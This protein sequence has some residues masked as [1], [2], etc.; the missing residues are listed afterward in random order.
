M[1]KSVCMMTSEESFCTNYGAPLQG[2]ALYRTISSLGYD[3]NIVRYKSGTCTR[4]Y[5]NMKKVISIIKNNNLYNIILKIRFRASQKLYNKKLKQRNGLFLHFQ[6]EYMTFCNDKRITWNELSK[7]PIIADIYVCGSDQLWNPKFRGNA[8]DKGYF[9]AFAPKETKLI[10]Y[11]PSLAVPS[12]SEE[13][14]KDMKCLLERFDYVSVREKTGAKIV[15]D[16]IEKEVPVMLDPAFLLTKKEWKEISKPIKTPKKYILC[17]VFGNNGVNID[18]ITKISK[19]LNLPVISLAMSAIAMA[20][21][22]FEK[23]YNVGPLEF[24][25]LVDNA[26][27]VVSDSFHATVF[28][29]IMETPFI[30]FTRAAKLFEGNDMNSRITNILEDVNL[31]HRIVNDHHDIQY[32]TLLNLDFTGVS[33]TIGQKREVS[34]K[35]LT[36]ALESN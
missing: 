12:V 7:N 26:E 10:A 25:D 36:A 31:K 18:I 14:K 8:N 20:E 2:Y 29:L 21:N 1:N 5:N 3:V 28:S 27:L 35:W 32:E 34:K 23:Y 9:L 33:K 15:S 13:I 17:Y 24:I 19:K 30:V 22:S 11:A 4:K 6:H 16:I